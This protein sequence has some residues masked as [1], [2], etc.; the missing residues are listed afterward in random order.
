M[1]A[2]TAYAAP[3]QPS[4]IP[5]A[6]FSDACRLPRLRSVIVIAAAVW[7]LIGTAGC[8][9]V[10][11]ASPA[12][13]PPHA[14]LTSLGGE[15]TVTMDNAGLDRSWSHACP[16]TFTKVVLPRPASALVA[17]GVVVAGVAIAGSLAHLVLPAGRGPPRG[18]AAALTGQD[19]LTRFSLARR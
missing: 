19:L 13:D 14:L 3:P 10:R 4:S 17:L 11:S 12:S 16:K 2:S 9:L 18:L 7:V 8:E 15:F 6:G 5:V 1:P